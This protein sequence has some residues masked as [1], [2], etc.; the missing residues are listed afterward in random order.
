MNEDWKDEIRRAAGVLQHRQL[1]REIVR[2]TRR[3][4]LLASRLNG[5]RF[6]AAWGWK[7]SAL[8]VLGQWPVQI[9]TA[10]QAYEKM[11]FGLRFVGR[12]FS[13]QIRLIDEE[14]EWDRGAFG[15][16]V[17][18]YE[19]HLFWEKSRTFLRLTQRESNLFFEGILTAMPFFLD[20]LASEMAILL[21]NAPGPWDAYLRYLV[22]WPDEEAQRVVDLHR[23]GVV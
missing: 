13:S 6:Y 3:R 14:E 21:P 4:R 15:K 1:S 11:F 19:L 5:V 8:S 9:V 18:T 7:E 17:P 10:R 23:G 20:R 16:R 22:A 2:A 12:D